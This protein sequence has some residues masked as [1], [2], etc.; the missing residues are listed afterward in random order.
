MYFQKP[1]AL[2]LNPAPGHHATRPGKL[3]WRLVKVKFSPVLCFDLSIHSPDRTAWSD[4]YV[5]LPQGRTR[6]H[7]SRPAST[8][9]G[10]CS[11]A[12]MSSSVKP[13]Q[14]KCSS[15]HGLAS[16]SCSH[17]YQSLTIPFYPLPCPLLVNSQPRAPITRHP[18]VSAR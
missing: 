15:P 16:T 7:R 14:K 2:P 10:T 9:A 8:C 5:N 12:G 3:K 6:A 18:M 11:G 17:L 4:R 13:F 1:D